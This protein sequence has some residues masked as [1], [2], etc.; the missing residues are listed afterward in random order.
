MDRLTETIQFISH[1]EKPL[2]MQQE[3][4]FSVL[5]AV[6]G[7]LSIIL[8]IEPLANITG[9]QLQFLIPITGILSIVMTVL[10]LKKGCGKT[11]HDVYLR[12]LLCGTGAALGVTALLLWVFAFSG[13]M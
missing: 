8:C 4:L 11:M 12:L 5:S 10:A 13:I 9:I 3:T 6:T 2:I 7:L 1:D